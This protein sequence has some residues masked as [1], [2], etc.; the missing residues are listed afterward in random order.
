M[1]RV[2]GAVQI[3]PVRPWEMHATMVCWPGEVNGA[4]LTWV[5]RI[6]Q[7]ATPAAKT[8]LYALWAYATSCIQE[9]SLGCWNQPAPVSLTRPS[10]K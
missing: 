5:M 4:S 1:V 8:S 7:S 6:S 9:L 3:H 10:E 2:S